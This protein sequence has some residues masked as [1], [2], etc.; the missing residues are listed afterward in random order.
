MIFSQIPHKLDSN[1]YAVYTNYEGDHTE[2]YDLIIGCSVSSLDNIPKGMK[3][4]SIEDGKYKKIETNGL[5]PKR[6]VFEGWLKV[7]DG[8]LNRSYNTDFE[9]YEHSSKPGIFNVTL[10]VGV[11]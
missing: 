2:P 8:D 10:Y 3:G 7:W 9:L 11:E 4:V 6:A 5:D 1:I